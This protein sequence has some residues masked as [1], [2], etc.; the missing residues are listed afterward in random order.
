MGRNADQNRRQREASM[1]RILDAAVALFAERGFHG[2]T[3]AAVADRAGISKGLV[4]SY[5]P[6]KDDLVVAAVERYVAGV[7]ELAA[8]VPPEHSPAQRLAEFARAIGRRTDE[9]PAWFLVHLRALADPEVRR[10]AGATSDGSGWAKAF[11][12]LGA[13]DPEL[14]G[15]FFQSA[16]LGILTHRVTSPV[17]TPVG[18]LI[19]RLLLST[20]GPLE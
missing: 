14:E 8:E 10:I 16:L 20:V 11:A 4:H 18:D 5:F 12:E 15:R 7:A 19:E 17:A 9:D 13:D 3:V 1:A 2:A 6:A